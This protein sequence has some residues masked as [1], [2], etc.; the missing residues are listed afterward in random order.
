MVDCRRRGSVAMDAKWTEISSFPQGKYENDLGEALFHVYDG[1]QAL[2]HGKINCTM[3]G[4][5]NWDAY[6]QGYSL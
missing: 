6:M 5:D 3:L 1:S 4:G 2:R